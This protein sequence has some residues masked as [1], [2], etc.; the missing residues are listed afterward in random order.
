MFGRTYEGM[1]ID[2]QVRFSEP[3]K[4]AERSRVLVTVL[5]EDQT[6]IGHVYT[7]RLAQPEQA[8][9]FAMEVEEARDACA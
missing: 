3:L 5:E 9:D 1:I 6:L 2:G 4:L 8:K 7:P